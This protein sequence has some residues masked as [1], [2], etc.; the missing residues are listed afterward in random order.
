M[1]ECAFCKTTDMPIEYPHR[2][3]TAIEQK[4]TIKSGFKQYTTRTQI[5]SPQTHDY[6]VCDRCETKYGKIF[7][8]TVLVIGILISILLMIFNHEDFWLKL[9]FF[10]P[11]PLAVAYFVMQFIGLN[12]K[13]K[14]KATSERVLA[15]GKTADIS[16]L[17]LDPQYQRAEKT[18][19][20][21]GYTE[22]E[23]EKLQS[24]NKV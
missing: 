5:F 11:I 6:I 8:G 14:K 19:R 12:L 10:F 4:S 15:H 21:L 17:E 16:L 13:L 7:P 3:I 22:A 2:I 18:V 23:F 1:S 24:S 20:Y 9:C